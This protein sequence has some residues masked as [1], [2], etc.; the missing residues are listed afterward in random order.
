MS[1]TKEKKYLRMTFNE[2]VQHFC[3]LTSFITLVITGF[4]LKF[5]EAL[6]VTW[7]RAVFGENFFELRGT[8]HRIAAVIMVS[9]SVY[10][11][12]YVI[13]TERGRKLIT[14]L[15]FKKTDVTDLFHTFSYYVGRSSTRP[16]FSRFSYIEKAEYWAVVWGTIV[17]GGTGTML[18]FENTFLPVLSNSGM[19]IATAIHYYEAILAS[20]AIVVWHFY[21][22]IY[23]PDVYPMN[24]AWYTGYLTREE[25]ELE[26]PLELEEIESQD[27]Q[28]EIAD[29][30][31]VTEFPIPKEIDTIPSV[32]EKPVE[33]KTDETPPPPDTQNEAKKDVKDPEREDIL[34]QNGD[35]TVNSETEDKKS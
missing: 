23:N 12:L 5:P 33:D 19:D 35:S 2:R 14:D 10:H 21:F 25:M 18:W 17:M 31:E 11:L 20:L 30:K 7:I 15:W 13:F 6:W 32:P 1:D 28:P 3:L 9:V 16:K 34:N 29:E 24:K 26:H 4:S 8:V 27:E 22:V